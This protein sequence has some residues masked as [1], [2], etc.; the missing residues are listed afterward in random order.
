MW[1]TVFMFPNYIIILNKGFTQAYKVTMRHNCAKIGQH[2]A[3]LLCH[4]SIRSSSNS[5]DY[6]MS[7]ISDITTSHLHCSSVHQIKN[8][9][10]PIL[11]LPLLGYPHMSK[12]SMLH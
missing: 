7:T 10:T 11:Y 5:A 9:V 1:M 6:S 2:L 8:I 12:D 3:L 4:C